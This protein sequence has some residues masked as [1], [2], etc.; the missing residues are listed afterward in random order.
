MRVPSRFAN[1]GF[2]SL[3]ACGLVTCLIAGCA[4]HSPRVV[5]IGLVAPFE[6][7]YREIGDAVIPAARLAIRQYAQ[8]YP[9]DNLV[10]ELVAYDDQG[11]PA[12]AQAQAAKLV[13]DPQVAVVIGNW[14]DETTAA[15]LPIYARANVPVITDT[16]REMSTNGIVYNLSPSLA[17]LRTVAESWRVDQ[18]RPTQIMDLADN[19]VLL[20]SD[21]LQ[22][23]AA[24]AVSDNLLGGPIWGSNQFWRLSGN[25]P[26][27]IYFVTGFALPG[28]VSS[29]FWT[30]ARV[31]LFTEG[32]VEGSLGA[33]PSMQSVA[34]YEATWLAIE[35]IA[36]ADQIVL[37]D[38]P[39][40]QSDFDPAGRRH[41]APIYLYRWHDGQ[42]QLVATLR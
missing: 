39:I 13:L 32:F 23:S 24:A 3:V 25:R 29:A 31:Q 4:S 34:A 38:L 17:E 30:R 21:V 41:D 12:L 22:G 8:L 15:A 2:V 20:A 40:R 9:D 16:S 18:S 11:V 10:L 6:G 5:K 28:D 26:Q 27:N 33:P 19:D 7:R 14:R 42:P 37:T 36:S 1:H 35:R